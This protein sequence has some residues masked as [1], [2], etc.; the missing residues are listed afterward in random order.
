M[1][2]TL[3]HGLGDRISAYGGST[4]SQGYGQAKAGLAMSTPIGAF[5]LD[6][7]YSRTQVRGLGVVG[8]QSWGLAYNKN[9]PFS[10]THFA[11]GAYRFSTAGYLNLPDALNVRELARQGGVSTVTP[12]RKA[13]ST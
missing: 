5:S 10:G 3:Q 9:L 1:Q 7:T 2:G 8:G 13:A 12:G 4:L 6:S 11:L